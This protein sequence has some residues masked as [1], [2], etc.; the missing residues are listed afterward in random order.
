MRE[1]PRC[2][3]F[4]KGKCAIHRFHLDHALQKPLFSTFFANFGLKVTIRPCTP[5]PTYCTNIPEFKSASIVCPLQL[6]ASLGHL[7]SV[8]DTA[9]YDQFF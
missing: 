5:L 2:D 9:L 4:P 3:L 1:M 6:S 7:Q 8:L